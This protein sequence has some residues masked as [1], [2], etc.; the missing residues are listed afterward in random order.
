MANRDADIMRQ[1]AAQQEPSIKWL[2]RLVIGLGIVTYILGFFKFK[3]DSPV[4]KIT[5][6]RIVF[7]AIFFVAVGM[8]LDPRVIAQ[9]WQA[10]LVFTVLVITCKLRVRGYVSEEDDRERAQDPSE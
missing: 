1:A 10:V 8:M 5:P 3:H 9:H 4:K 7:A 2:T 6:L